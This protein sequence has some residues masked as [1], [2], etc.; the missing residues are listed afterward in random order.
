MKHCVLAANG[1][2]NDNNGANFNNINVII[3]GKNF[4]DQL[5]LWPTR[6]SDRSHDFSVTIPRCYKDLY[7]NSFF[8]RTARLWDSLSIE[9]FPLIY[10]RADF[11]IH[12]KHPT[13][14]D[15]LKLIKVLVTVDLN[16]LSSLHIHGILLFLQFPNFSLRF[17]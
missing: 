6:Y 8:P 9:C 10:D 1:N 4:Y 16:R 15:Y 7:V 12:G 3:N 11:R 13:L 14:P 5:I 2:E 17:W